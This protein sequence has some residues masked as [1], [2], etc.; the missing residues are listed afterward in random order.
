M[1]K[2][3]SGSISNETVFD[4]L[5]VESGGIATS[6]S[7]EGGEEFVESGGAAV[8][9]VV[10]G[11][12]G[13]PGTFFG[14]LIVDGG[15]SFSATAELYGEIIVQNGG[16]ALLNTVLSGGVLKV[17]DTGIANT[18]TV[19]A[20]GQMFVYDGGTAIGVTI[21]D[22]GVVNVDNQFGF[23]PATP[24]GG[25]V[26]GSIVDNGVLIYNV[27]SGTNT[28][29]AMGTNGS[30]TGTGVVE[31]LTGDGW[32]ANGPIGGGKLVVTGDS[33]NNLTFEI[34]NTSPSA[35]TANTAGPGQTLEFQAASNNFVSFSGNNN[36]LQLD[37]SQGF[38][39]TVA[40][41]TL[42][43]NSHIDLAD[44]A[45]GSGTAVHF[46]QFGSEGVLAVSNNG[47]V[48]A[49]LVLLGNY[50]ASDFVAG[51]D[52]N[53]GTSIAYTNVV[54]PTPPG[55]LSAVAPHLHG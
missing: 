19:S 21:Q 1:P 32:P 12:P 29:V 31:V 26:E 27:G 4:T 40:G 51:S 38:S 37:D 39:G 6:I 34:V 5:F 50:I 35:A 20:G 18:D 24:T 15:F 45:F 46:T 23:G 55:G 30:L 16:S 49:G 11:G 36:T 3:I 2:T 7:I 10:S 13:D 9:T 52:G 22:G 47:T 43:N 28:L 33:Q 25:T 14:Q 44:V 54:S 42:T 17:Q 8:M 53:G 48:V 41:M